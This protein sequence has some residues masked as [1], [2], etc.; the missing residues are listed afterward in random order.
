MLLEVI[1]QAVDDAQIVIAY[2]HE[3]AQIGRGEGQLRVIELRTDVVETVSPG[4]GLCD[5]VGV[6]RNPRPAHDDDGDELDELPFGEAL[7]QPFDRR[8]GNGI[9]FRSRFRLLDENLVQLAMKGAVR[10]VARTQEAVRADDDR[11]LDVSRAALHHGRLTAALTTAPR[12]AAGGWC[13]TRAA[14]PDAA[15]RP[16]IPRF[17]PAA[18]EFFVMGIRKDK[19]AYH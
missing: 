9:G 19:H 3:T 1:D 15:N 7:A 18:G 11:H 8:T 2:R 12:P 6:L 5:V 10:F 14:Q 4:F 16:A 13:G 17:P